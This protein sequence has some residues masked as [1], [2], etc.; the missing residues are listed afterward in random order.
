MEPIFNLKSLPERLR[1]L[2][3]R[4]TV[5]VACP[6]DSHTEEVVERSIREE[7]ADFILVAVAGKEAV[8]KRLLADY[9]EHV[10]IIDAE[11]DDDAARKA[12]WEVH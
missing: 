5:A 11:D 10:V 4:V 9:P 3:K 8:A 1:S 7:I 12:V 6:A 2:G